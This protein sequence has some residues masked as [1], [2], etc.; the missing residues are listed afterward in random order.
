MRMRR[1][2]PSFLVTMLATWLFNRWLARRQA[3]T[4]PLG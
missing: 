2:V 3:R 4:R 1:S